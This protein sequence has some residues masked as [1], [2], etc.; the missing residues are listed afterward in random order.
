MYY[1]GSSSRYF[2][3][4]MLS[5]E[6]PSLRDLSD[7]GFF[8]SSS[9]L[10]NCW[11]INDRFTRRDCLYDGSRIGEILTRLEKEE[12]LSILQVSLRWKV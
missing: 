4:E 5:K 7:R 11:K 8:D 6:T 10:D 2:T 12:T 1:S 9:C 3:I